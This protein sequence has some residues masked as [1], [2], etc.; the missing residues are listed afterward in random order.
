MRTPLRLAIA[1]AAAAIGALTAASGATA[2]TPTNHVGF[3]NLALTEMLGLD[4]GLAVTAPAAGEANQG[5]DLVYATHLATTPG[6][7]SPYLLRN[8]ETG[9]CLADVGDGRNVIAVECEASPAADSAQLW[10]NHR[11]ADRT[12]NGRDYYIRFNRASGRV[13]TAVP[14]SAGAGARVVSAPAQP[15][16]KGGAA[17]PQLWV[18]LAL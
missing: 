4:S 1:S 17:D 14:G 7:S 2:D 11:T 18:M 5:W 9:T 16:A 13:L 10:Q 8:R 6:F 12:V 15:V 3:A